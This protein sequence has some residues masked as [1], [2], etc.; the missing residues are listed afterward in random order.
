MALLGTMVTNK[1]RRKLRYPWTVGA[2]W[3]HAAGGCS[4]LSSYTIV[5]LLLKIVDTVSEQRFAKQNLP[6]PV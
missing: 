5:N 1:K 2:E 3:P 4:L 6:V